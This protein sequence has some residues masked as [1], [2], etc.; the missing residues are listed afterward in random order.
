MIGRGAYGRP[1]IA[2]SIGQALEKGC[3]MSEPSLSERL[4]IALTHF[5]D[6]LRFYGD[7]HGLKIFRKHLGWYV[8]QALCPADPAERRAVKS[9]LCQIDN[10]HG[11]ETALAALWSDSALSIRATALI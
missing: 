1:W 4:E 9:R 8:E 6:T 3:E 7:R 2:A 11:I 5:H 10:A